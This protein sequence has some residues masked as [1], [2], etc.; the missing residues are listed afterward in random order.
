[1]LSKSLVTIVEDVWQALATD[2]LAQS[3]ITSLDEAEAISR[4]QVEELAF[5]ALA[6]KS[7]DNSSQASLQHALCTEDLPVD[8]LEAIHLH[9][10]SRRFHRQPDGELRCRSSRRHRRSQGIYYTPDY[11]AE[12]LTDRC[13]ASWR[14]LSPPRILDPACGCGRFLLTAARQLLQQGYNAKDVAHALHGC[15]LDEEAVL[16]A[17]RML[18]LTLSEDSDSTDVATTLETNIACTNSLID[19]LPQSSSSPRFPASALSSFDII[20]GNPPYRREL[21]T[22]GLLDQIAETD[23]GRRY[24]AP[25]MDLWYYF[26]H[27]GIE[28]LASGGRLGFIVGAYW[29]AGTGANRL[30]QT[31]REA[32]HVEEIFQLD[33]LQVFPGVAGHHMMLVLS[34]PPSH[35]PTTVR[36]PVFA[37]PTDARPYVEGHGKVHTFTKSSEQL[38][39]QGL[40]DLEPPAEHLLELLSQFPI[41]GQ[42]GRIRQG[43]AE[44]PATVTRATNRK[45]G[46]LWQI[47][48][49]VFTLSS[50]ELAILDLPQAEQELVRPYHALCDLGRYDR[51]ERPS[52]HLVYS[53]RETWPREEDHPVLLRHLA[54]FRPIME[55]RRETHRGTRSWWQLHWPRE[56]QIWSQAKLIA[57]QMGARPAFVPAQEPTYVSFSSNVFLPD[58]EVREHL[59]YFAAL[60]NSRL[61]WKWFRHHAKRRGVGLEINGHVLSRAPIRRIDFT[62]PQDKATHDRLVELVDRMLG[63]ADRRRTASQPKIDAEWLKTDGLIDEL[64]YELYDLPRD[65]SAAI[66]ATCQ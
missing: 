39:R 21:G 18:T 33:R 52:R 59:N 43:I 25:R 64:V 48:E 15:D 12:Y 31:L 60:L 66:E 4:R 58:S 26:L 9:L 30:I 37:K 65:E 6:E 19:T 51:A 61:L 7:A 54:R 46:D 24:R 32:V 38:F 20:L 8:V 34:K 50:E 5:Q 28:L 10:L 2:L 3:A 63:L 53:T 47:G 56:A 23:F 36:L 1:M 13:L 41:L 62:S 57:L 17:R 40:L 27:R 14:R 11:I 22:K 29:A 55:A 49:G 45:H 35:A 44:N 16:T 42:L